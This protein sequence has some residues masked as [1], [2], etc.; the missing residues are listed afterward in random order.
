MPRL[1]HIHNYPMD[2]EYTLEEVRLM[3]AGAAPRVRVVILFMASSGI[4]IGTFDYMNVGDVKQLDM[5]GKVVCGELK[6]YAGEG[7]DEY[8]TLISK[9]AH[10]E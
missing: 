2:R 7:N 1:V 5:D 3:L 8:T 9:E 10:G 6:T 4:R